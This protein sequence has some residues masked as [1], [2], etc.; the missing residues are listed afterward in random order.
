M[1]HLTWALFLLA[2]CGAVSAQQHGSHAQTASP[3]ATLMSG[4]GDLHHPVSTNNAEAQKFFDQG[5]RLIYAFNHEEAAHSFQ[6]AAK[7]DPKM[8]MAYWGI[9]EAVGPNYNDPA[10]P[11]RY[12]QAHDAIQ[13]AG[14]LA[15]DASPSEKAYIAA[16]AVR[17]PAD[18][19][20]DHR[21][22]AERYRNAIG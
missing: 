2:T 10:D 13:K 21:L 3:A 16:M 12:K 11:D 22:A 8:A 5:L 1:K 17:F 15:A 18:P 4:Y 19:N 14:D 9:A 6:Q 7:L 20:A